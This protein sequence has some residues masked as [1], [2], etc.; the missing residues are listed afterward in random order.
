MTYEELLIQTALEDERIIVMT[1]ENRALVRNIPKILGPRF[2]DTGITEQ[3][4][5]GMAAGLALRGR[6]PIVH[7]LAPFLTM[8]AY[9]FIRTDVGIAH[10]PVKLSGYIPGFLSDGNGPTHQSIED[11][12]IMRGIPGMEV[13]APADEDD[14]VK[15]LPHIWSAPAPAYTRINHKKGNFTHAPYQPGK[16]EVVAEGTD[17]TLLVYGFLFENALQAKSLLEKEGLSVGLVNMRSL[18]PVDEEAIVRAATGS[19]HLVTIEDHLQ[20]GGLYSIV[21]EVLLRRRVSAAVTALS[22]G[23]RWFRPGL[24]AQVLETEGFTPE[25]IAATVKENLVSYAK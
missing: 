8:R 23:E 24:L 21:A 3:T 5:V 10:L 20:T 12:S 15:M 2:V 4:M 11:V 18:K 25:K 13:Y 9:E 22:L 19:Q 1:A 6:I 7:A 14:L 17:V 16:A